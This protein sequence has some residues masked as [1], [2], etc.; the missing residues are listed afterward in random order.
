MRLLLLSTITGLLFSAGAYAQAGCSDAGVCTLG[1]HSTEGPQTSDLI[2]LQATQTFSAN[3]DYSYLETY[4]AASAAFANF[5]LE[6]GINYRVARAR[7]TIQE[8]ASKPVLKRGPSVLHVTQVVNRVDRHYGPGD[9]KAIL[10]YQLIPIVPLHFHAGFTTPLR[11]LYADRPQ[12]MQTTLGVPSLLLGASLDIGADPLMIGATLAYQ[13]TFKKQNSLHLTRADD[14][15]LTGRASSKLSKLQW[16]LD[17][18][19][20]YHLDEDIL[21]VTPVDGTSGLTVNLGGSLMYNLPIGL[22][23]GVFGALPIT[24]IEHVDGLKRSYVVGLTA[25]LSVL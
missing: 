16:G 19:A 24:S 10:S 5:G 13:T 11:D 14:L 8:P 1:G 23:V 21:H 18:S 12:D 22:E 3:E 4:A 6:V 20:I 15:A 17:L 2:R 9:L 7:Y 25:A